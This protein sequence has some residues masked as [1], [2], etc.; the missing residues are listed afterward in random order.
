MKYSKSAVF[1]FTMA[2]SS[3]NPG[4][5]EEHIVSNLRIYPGDDVLVD[6]VSIPKTVPFIVTS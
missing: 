1:W 3:E 4:V 6:G 2:C 5:V